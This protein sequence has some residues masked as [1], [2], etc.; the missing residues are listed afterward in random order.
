MEALNRVISSAYAINYRSISAPTHDFAHI[1][2]LRGS[3]LREISNLVPIR[4]YIYF[5]FFGS[6]QKRN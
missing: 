3:P 5:S 6:V 2:G 1:C 4:Q